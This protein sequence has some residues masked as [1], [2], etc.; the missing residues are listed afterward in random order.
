MPSFI[1]IQVFSRRTPYAGGD[2]GAAAWAPVSA[3]LMKKMPMMLNDRCIILGLA[4]AAHNIREA[5]AH[6]AAW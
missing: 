2:G 1:G 5:A 4:C 3:A 6:A